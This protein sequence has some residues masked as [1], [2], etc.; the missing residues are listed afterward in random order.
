MVWRCISWT[1]QALAT[2][3]LWSIV[4]YL[5]LGRRNI[6]VAL[7]PAIFMTYICASF[8]FVSSQFVGLGATATAYLCGG[9]ATLVILVIMIYKLRKDAKMSA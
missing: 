2:I 1:N 7:L 5:N 3:V 4:V 8:V 6:W 9:A